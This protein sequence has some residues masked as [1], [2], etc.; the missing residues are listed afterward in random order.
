MAL[1]TPPSD[2]AAVAGTSE[3]QQADTGTGGAE[4]RRLKPKL[5][6][7][8][9]ARLIGTW[10]DRFFGTRTLILRDDG[11][12][13]M[14]LDLD[15]T[16]SLMYGRHLE[17]DMQW[18]LADAT[19]QIEILE[20]FPEKSAQSLIKTWGTRFEY[21]LDQVDSDAVEMRDWDGSMS[22][23]LRRAAE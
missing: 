17:F 4:Q 15:L 21:L 12:A 1:E 7:V 3:P 2:S 10:K 19:V 18:T 8:E 6:H 20:G 23:S 16:A 5:A 14:I 9:R 22:Y 11:T 13:R